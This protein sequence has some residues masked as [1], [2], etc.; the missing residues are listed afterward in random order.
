MLLLPPIQLLLAQWYPLKAW[1]QNNF[2]APV[3]SIPNF[4]LL[5]IYFIEFLTIMPGQLHL[6]VQYMRR[7]RYWP[8]KIQWQNWMHTAIEDHKEAFITLRLVD[9]EEGLTLNSRYRNKLYATN[10]LSF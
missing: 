3:K 1:N 6:T 2:L 7:P 9:A 5:N 4:N 8:I 10:I